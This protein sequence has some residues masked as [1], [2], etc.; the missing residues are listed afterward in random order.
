MRF[1]SRVPWRFSF[2]V[3]ILAIFVPCREP[4][5]SGSPPLSSRS[6]YI[7]RFL[8][9]KTAEDHRSYIENK[10]GWLSGWRWLERRNPAASFPTDFGLLAIEDSYRTEVI[11]ELERLRLVKDVVIDSSFTRSL[12]AESRKQSGEFSELKKHPGKLFT[13]MSFEGGPIYTSL[14]NS[15]ISWRRL[16]MDVR[17]FPL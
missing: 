4:P 5:G 17:C 7:V 10:I 12:S 8:E 9:Y 15:S 14:S 1:L 16:M 3:L 13:S 11:S 6:N 2:L